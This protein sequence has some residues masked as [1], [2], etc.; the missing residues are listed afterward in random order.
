MDID[1]HRRKFF[2]VWGII[3]AL[4]FL[5]AR[6]AKLEERKGPGAGHATLGVVQIYNTN[7]LPIELGIKREIYRKE[8][9]ELDHL[10]M[11]PFAVMTG[12]NTK[13]LDYGMTGSSGVQS[14]AAGLPIKTVLVMRTRSGMSIMARPGISS[15]KEL[16]GKVIGVATIGDAMDYAA[17]AILRHH[18]LDPERDAIIRPV[19]VGQLTFL[20]VKTGAVDAG[21]MNVIHLLKLEHEKRGFKELM[22]VDE[23]VKGISNAL[24]V[25][26]K[27]LKDNPAEI[28]KMIRGTLKALAYTRE[29]RKDSTDH[30]TKVWGLEK[31]LVLPLYDREKEAYSIN[32]KAP[33]E[34]FQE[35]V[36][37][38]QERGLI[39]PKDIPTSQLRDF[40]LLEEVLKEMGIK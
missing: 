28:K 37:N 5:F 30:M 11:K 8:G 35:V 26:V 16:K 31:E 27:K 12:L 39:P 40:T 18:G 34:N 22:A 13:D 9:I 19:G 1:N 17:R 4:V 14:S 20:A 23:V 24:Q 29:N 2:I 6:G 21:L 36:K 32:G 15:V 7:T 38:S 25:S 3:M 33:D 10:L